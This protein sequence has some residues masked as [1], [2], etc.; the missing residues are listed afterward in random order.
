MQAQINIHTQWTHELS[1]NA[2]VNCNTTCALQVSF[3]SHTGQN[4]LHI[5]PPPPAYLS[6]VCVCVCVMPV[7]PTNLSAFDALIRN[8]P[9]RVIDHMDIY[10]ATLLP[11]DIIIGPIVIMH[12]ASALGRI[13]K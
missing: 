11:V 13:Y 9:A 8:E 3:Q 12:I 7:R 1:G 6:C 5:H 2:R 10:T 4:T